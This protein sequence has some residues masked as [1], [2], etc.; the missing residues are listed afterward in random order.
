MIPYDSEEEAVATANDTIYGLS[1]VVV[2]K[3]LIDPSNNQGAR[4][5]PTVW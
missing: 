3:D 2:F 4:D 5:A 1:N